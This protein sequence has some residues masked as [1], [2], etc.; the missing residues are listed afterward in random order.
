M[1]LVLTQQ[2]QAVF[3]GSRELIVQEYLCRLLLIALKSKLK[4]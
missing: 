1:K 2:K 4:S 3:H